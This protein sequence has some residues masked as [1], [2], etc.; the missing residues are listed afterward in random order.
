MNAVIKFHEEFI[1]YLENN[2]KIENN[3]FIYEVN[4]KFNSMIVPT[5]MEATEVENNIFIFDTMK[6]VYN[7]KKEIK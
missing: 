4:K 3:K 1:K 2:L 5:L 7:K 6:N